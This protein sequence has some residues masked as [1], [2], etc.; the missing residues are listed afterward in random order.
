MTDGVQVID[1]GTVLGRV[2]IATRDFQA[3]DVVLAEL[4]AIIFK[5]DNEYFGLWNAYLAA[6]EEKQ[7]PFWK[8]I[9]L[10]PM[11]LHSYLRIHA[12]A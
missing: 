10:Q 5:A 9:I 7:S 3:G 11:T 2:T 1:S 12:S 8:R 4:P 6:P